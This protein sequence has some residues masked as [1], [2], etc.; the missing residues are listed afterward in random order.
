MKGKRHQAETLPQ[1]VGILLPQKLCGNLHLFFTELNS[2]GIV[3][4]NK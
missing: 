4:L 3:D 1:K 2:C